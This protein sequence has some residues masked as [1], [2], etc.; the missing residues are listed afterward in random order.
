MDVDLISS[1][2]H[3]HEPRG[4]IL[5]QAGGRTSS[6]VPQ[7]L[8]RVGSLPAAV[9]GM[10]AG[11]VLVAQPRAAELSS[12]ICACGCVYTYRQPEQVCSCLGDQC[13]KCIL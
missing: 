10:E 1:S 2:P 11:L 6:L 9:V 8:S 5:A 12:H 13:Q 7:E 3:F 4:Q